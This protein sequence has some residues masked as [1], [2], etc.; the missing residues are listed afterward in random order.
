V[1]AHTV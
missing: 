1:T